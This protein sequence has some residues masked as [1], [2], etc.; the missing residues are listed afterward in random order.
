MTNKDIHII[1]LASYVTPKPVEKRGDEWVSYGEDDDFY[2]VLL[3]SKGSPT[4]S[5]LINSITDLIY[6]KGLKATNASKNPEMYATVVSLL[7]QDTLRRA[8]EEY[9]H[10]GCAYLQIE[11]D[12]A[13]EKIV[14]VYHTPT[15]NWR[16][17]KCNEDGDILGYYFHD[18]WLEMRPS[19]QPVRYS[20][21]G[22]SRDK[23]EILRIQP[24]RAGHVYFAPV[25]W[26]SGLQYAQMEIEISNYHINNIINGF[27]ANTIINFNNG[28]PKDDEREEIEGKIKAKFTG[29]SNAGRLILAFNE[30]GENAA[31]I[32]TVQLNNAHEQYQF[33]SEEC[34]RKILVSHRVTSPILL[35]LPH[36]SGF[37]NNAE[38]LKTASQLFDNTVIKPQQRQFL[39][40]LTPLFDAM[41][42]SLDFYFETLQ[43]LDFTE[44]E[45]DEIDQA[46][47]EEKTG[48]Q[49]SEI[50]LIDELGER[51]EDLKGWQMV[52]ESDVDYESDSEMNLQIQ[53]INEEEEEQRLSKLSKLVNLVSTGTA[54]P[55]AGSD[56]DQ[57]TK[58]K[59]F[60]VRYEYAPRKV[61]SDSR[62]FC[63][64]MVSAAKLYRREDID[65]MSASV[66]NE[67]W[68]PNG[69]N[70]YDIFKYKGGGDCHHRW[71]RKVFARLDDNGNIDVKSP[72][73]QSL[74]TSFR[75]AKMNGYDRGEDPDYDKAKTRPKDMPNNGFLK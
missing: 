40:G 75:E 2:Q 12:V 74:I 16:P 37:G 44:V 66:V 57:R 55:N 28:V 17:E 61:S 22:T 60:K 59:Y 10:L 47:K 33:I 69:A 64:R 52:S 45:N 32:E 67:G 63:R 58:E 31:Q 72:R 41:N 34:A 56:W 51:E 54:R 42:V 65:Q 13:H 30:S 68:G 73:A 53:I 1:H 35:G 29:S 50:N 6:G 14:A 62:E 48:V 7:K 18:N 71:V 20:A 23:T 19:D 46:K 15:P 38:E 27:S 39:E 5:A 43:P 36:Q 70:K 9:Y 4:N 3:D 8:I 24:Y 11:W 49:M 25:E 26:S 21:F